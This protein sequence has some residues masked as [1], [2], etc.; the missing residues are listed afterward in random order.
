MHF[1]CPQL[2]TTADQAVLLA[3]VPQHSQSTRAHEAHLLWMRPHS[4][5]GEVSLRVVVGNCWYL[6]VIMWRPKAISAD[7]G[8]LNTAK[9]F[10]LQ[11]FVETTFFCMGCF[12]SSFNSE[13]FQSKKENS[14]PQGLCLL[15]LV[16]DGAGGP[17][18]V[19][20]GAL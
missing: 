18:T 6:I 1:R 15:Q 13:L 5:R 14:F 20:H 3:S 11:G 2:S 7:K 10:F 17:C 9:Y 16:L 12:L 8:L 4:F 19:V